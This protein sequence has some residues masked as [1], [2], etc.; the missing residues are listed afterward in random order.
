MGCPPEVAYWRRPEARRWHCGSG[1]E[2]NP[3]ALVDRN[4]G[5][6]QIRN[7]PRT[8]GLE[9][10][11]QCVFAAVNGIEYRQCK[12]WGRA[13][14]GA[15]RAERSSVSWHRTRLQDFEDRGC[16]GYLVSQHLTMRWL[17]TFVLLTLLSLV[18]ALSS[19]GNRLLAVIEEATEKEKYSQ[20]WGDLKGTRTGIDWLHYG[21]SGWLL[22]FAIDRGFSIT[23]ESPKSEKLALFRHGE[24][25][26]DHII[27]LP[28]KS[29]GTMHCGYAFR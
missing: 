7:C 20:F 16:E 17:F 27:L 25:A 18:Q 9:C 11:R 19:S 24:R 21:G 13:H 8:I 10:S 15:G 28:P 4:W 14:A 22:C 29:K 6:A 12:R 26:Y 3:L 5:G 23:F 1:E 2:G